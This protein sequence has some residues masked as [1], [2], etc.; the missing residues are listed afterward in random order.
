MYEEERAMDFERRG[1][2]CIGSH[3]LP[4]NL[5]TDV[6]GCSIYQ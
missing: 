1:V 6:L 5:F 3:V 2:A 4:G